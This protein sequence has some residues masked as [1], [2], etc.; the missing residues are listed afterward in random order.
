MIDISEERT[1]K[2]ALWVVSNS[3][4]KNHET[5]FSLDVQPQSRM[6]ASAT[7]LEKDLSEEEKREKET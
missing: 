4:E 5:H 3:F 2:C 6:H 7:A 1:L